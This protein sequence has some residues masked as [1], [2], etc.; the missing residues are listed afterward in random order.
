MIVTFTQVPQNT[1]RAK[2]KI[3]YA[4]SNYLFL[5]QSSLL[6]IY[7]PIDINKDTVDSPLIHSIHKI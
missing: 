3:L 7:Y 2:C 1:Y 6:L 5:S 4:S